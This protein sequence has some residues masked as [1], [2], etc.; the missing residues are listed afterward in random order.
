MQFGEHVRAGRT[1]GPFSCIFFEYR[2]VKAREVIANCD[3]R[4][5]ATDSF[6]ALRT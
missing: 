4:R 5:W 3:E 6:V 1:G 2:S